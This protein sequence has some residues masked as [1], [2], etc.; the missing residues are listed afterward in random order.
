MRCSANALA[1]RTGIRDRRGR[2]RG[3]LA[4]ATESVGVVLCWA[5]T[6]SPARSV[7]AEWWRSLGRVIGEIPVEPRR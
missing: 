5:E 2:N 6:W 3:G 1:V 7:R 4:F